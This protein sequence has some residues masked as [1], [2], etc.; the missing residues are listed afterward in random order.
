M[1]WVRCGIHVGYTIFVEKMKERDNLGYPV[2]DV[3]ESSNKDHRKIGTGYGPEFD[4]LSTGMG[5]LVL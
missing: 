3:E 2:L 1:S 5:I 4:L